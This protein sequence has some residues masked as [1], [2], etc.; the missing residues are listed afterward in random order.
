MHLRD[1]VLQLVPLLISLHC[2]LLD[3][4][5]FMQSG[6]PTK[7]LSGPRYIESVHWAQQLIQPVEE[8]M[9]PLV[10]FLLSPLSEWI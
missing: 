5:E 9:L 10:D 7:L 3:L 6:R 1:L 2:K 8:G 4:L